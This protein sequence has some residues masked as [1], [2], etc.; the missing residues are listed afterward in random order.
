MW[1]SI[2]EV[3]EQ[4]GPRCSRAN[5]WVLSSSTC[6]Y[7]RPPR[8]S[9]TRRVASAEHDDNLQHA[10]TRD[11]TQLPST[12]GSWQPRRMA[13]HGRLPRSSP[14]ESA[15]TYS[16][17]SEHARATTLEYP[18]RHRLRQSHRRGARPSNDSIEALKL[19]CCMASSS[20]VAAASSASSRADSASSA[21]HSA[22]SA[23]RIC[24]GKPTCE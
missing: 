14:T 8:L 15:S 21:A 4:F 17:A 22:R 6:G 16:T 23:S 12:L 7:F 2:Q 1:S 18:L 13:E 24:R 20:A 3:D 9:R 19:A 10:A 5:E 11:D